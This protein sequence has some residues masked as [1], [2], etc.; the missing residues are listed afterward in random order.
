MTIQNQYTFIA[1]MTVINGDV[2]S[3]YPVKL[4]ASDIPSDVMKRFEF[5]CNQ[6]IDDGHNQNKPSYINMTYRTGKTMA[7]LNTA[8][9]NQRYAVPKQLESHF[10]NIVNQWKNAP[11]DTLFS[12]FYD[13]ENDYTPVSTSELSELLTDDFYN[14]LNKQ[15]GL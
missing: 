3:R 14:N 8:I 6:G 1:V 5:G 12:D 15:G 4:L 2:E 11:K 13:I 7:G 10:L 9:Y